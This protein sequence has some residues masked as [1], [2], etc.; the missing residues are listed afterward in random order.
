MLFQRR[1]SRE[2]V[3]DRVASMSEWVLYFYLGA[4]VG[5]GERVLAGVMETVLFRKIFYFSIFINVR[6]EKKFLLSL[7][8]AKIEIIH[9]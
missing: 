2:S 4:S 8:H 6:V 9:S 3:C 7:F 5:L 1:F